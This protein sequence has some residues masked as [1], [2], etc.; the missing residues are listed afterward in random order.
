MRQV[1]DIQELAENGYDYDDICSIL[2]CEISDIV[3]ILGEEPIDIEEEVEF[4]YT[5]RMVIG[6]KHKEQV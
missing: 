2:G 3:G 1:A 5:K 4:Y 6:L